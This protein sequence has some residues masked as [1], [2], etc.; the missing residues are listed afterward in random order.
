MESL[1]KRIK[2]SNKILDDIEIIA[3]AV[4]KKS[5]K[6][7]NKSIDLVIQYNESKTPFVAI[8]LVHQP[9]DNSV[10]RMI[11]ETNDSFESIIKKTQLYLAQGYSIELSTANLKA[12]S[13]TNSVIIDKLLENTTILKSDIKSLL[14]SNLSKGVPKNQLIRELKNLYPAY[15][16]NAGTIINTGLSREY[17]DINATKFEEAGFKWYIWAGPNDK[18]TRELP[19]QHW[20]N[21]KFPASQ[22]HILRSTRQSLWNCRHSIIPITEEEVKDFPDGNISFAS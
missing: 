16:R 5:E 1:D 4:K 8:S 9:I 12:I 7:Y 22:L 11:V 17:Q 18:L 14:Y 2:G 21:H 10:R 13:Q 6:I 3:N 19:C 20:T 15:S